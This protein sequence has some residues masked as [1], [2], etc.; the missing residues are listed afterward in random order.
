MFLFRLIVSFF[1]WWFCFSHLFWGVALVRI[2]FISSVLSVW[3]KEDWDEK[4]KRPRETEIT[5]ER[6]W[7][8]DWDETERE[9]PT[10]PWPEQTTPTKQGAFDGFD[11]RWLPVTWSA[12]SSKPVTNFRRNQGCDFWRVKSIPDG[13]EERFP[14]R[15]VEEKLAFFYFYFFYT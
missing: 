14:T 4:R 1:L 10:N 3:R 15:N 12:I 6:D 9:D 13:L 8:G 7:M 11:F 5:R 2:S